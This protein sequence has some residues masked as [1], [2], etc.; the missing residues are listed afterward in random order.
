MF[1]CCQE[2]SHSIHFVHSASSSVPNTWRNWPRN[3][4]FV[5]SLRYIHSTTFSGPYVSPR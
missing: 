4:A 2:R 3:E 5:P 1:S